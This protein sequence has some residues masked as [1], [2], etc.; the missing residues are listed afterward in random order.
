LNKKFNYE[1]YIDFQKDCMRLLSGR[2]LDC[3]AI[4]YPDHRLDDIHGSYG[5]VAVAGKT[6]YFRLFKKM[7]TTPKPYDAVMMYYGTNGDKQIPLDIKAMYGKTMDEIQIAL[8]L[9]A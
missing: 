5:L 6:T 7:L 2:L 1:L 8:D 4:R 9:A 3:L